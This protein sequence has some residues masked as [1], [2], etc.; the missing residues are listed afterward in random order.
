MLS[1]WWGVGLAYSE[2]TTHS[3]LATQPRVKNG[4]VEFETTSAHFLT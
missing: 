3:E 4:L 2:Q 1:H